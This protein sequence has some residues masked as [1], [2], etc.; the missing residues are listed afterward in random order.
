MIDENQQGQQI[1][2]TS[3]SSAASAGSAATDASPLTIDIADV[4]QPDLQQMLPHLS[5]RSSMNYEQFGLPSF[6]DTFL[7][8]PREQLQ[9]TIRYDQTQNSYPMMFNNPT[10]YTYPSIHSHHNSPIGMYPFKVDTHSAHLSSGYLNTQL[11][12]FLHHHTYENFPNNHSNFNAHYSQYQQAVPSPPLPPQ[13]LKPVPQYEHHIKHAEPQKREIQTQTEVQQKARP[14]ASQ[15]APQKKE[16]KK[17]KIKKD[18]S[19][20]DEDT[21]SDNDEEAFVVL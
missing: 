18:A 14:P 2:T 4:T 16:K 21:N 6:S 9:P 1:V 17:R 20:D 13:Y 8:G 12:G 10:A 7:Q 19:S 11:D 15:S 3:V 5:E